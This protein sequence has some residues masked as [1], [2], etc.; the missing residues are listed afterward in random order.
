MTRHLA[1]LCA[2]VAI[3]A[4]CAHAPELAAPR[5]L[6]YRTYPVER[7][8][9]CA[10]WNAPHAPVR[11]FGNTY[12]VGTAELG[13]VL[14]TSSR[15]H[16]LIDSALPESAPQII[17]NIRLLGFRIEDVVLLL[18]SHA[19]YDHAGGLAAVQ[20]ASGA[21][22]VAT[23]ASSRE[24][25][26][27]TA[28]EDDPQHGLAEDFPPVRVARSVSDGQVLEV[29]PLAVT[30]HATGGHTPGSTTWTWQSCAD[31]RCVSIVY[32]D[33]LT[34]LSAP[35]YRYTDH[36]ALLAAFAHSLELIERI[37]C[38][39]LVTPHASATALWNRVAAGSLIDGEA[40]RRYAA[41]AR[42]RLDAQLSDERGRPEP[43]R[44]AVDARR[45]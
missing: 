18:N 6:P 26:R 28:D 45:P 8:P 4:A 22:V 2:S 13:A 32:A 15:G 44:P 37:P 19:H 43:A 9:S 31:G 3:L 40:C 35:S 1:V 41:A 25:T 30:A 14:I 23:A 21:E 42:A 12:W 34:A 39:V 7:C 20:E 33:S 10:E 24:L 5:P 17:G 38:D 16:I 27:G 11:I 29:G 36:P